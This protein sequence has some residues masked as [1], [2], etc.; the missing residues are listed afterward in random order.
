MSAQNANHPLITWINGMIV[1]GGAKY[2]NGDLYLSP[3][4]ARRFALSLHE[5]IPVICW[6]DTDNKALGSVRWKTAAIAFNLKNHDW[7]A[8]S[9]PDIRVKNSAALNPVKLRIFIPINAGRLDPWKEVMPPKIG[10]SVFKM[11]NGKP[12]LTGSPISS[13]PI[14]LVG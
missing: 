8:L 7:I 13:I 3:I 9:C 12:V 14:K 4:G 11:Q 1:R 6:S 2:E 5:Q 10:T